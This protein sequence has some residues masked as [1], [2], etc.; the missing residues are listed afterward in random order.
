MPAHKRSAKEPLLNTFARTLGY[1][2][3]T[4]TSVAQEWTENLATLPKT[5][6]G[7]RRARPT[8]SGRPKKKATRAQPANAAKGATAAKKKTAGKKKIAAR[9]KSG[10]GQ[11]NR[12]RNPK[13][14]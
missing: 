2:A 7:K 8:A 10:G 5:V 3:G 4:L 14:K 12:A 9:K 1:A 6:S 13:K 11:R